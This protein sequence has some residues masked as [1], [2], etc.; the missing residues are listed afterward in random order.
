MEVTHTVCV[1]SSRTYIINTNDK[2][3]CKMSYKTHSTYVGWLRARV[4]GSL[5]H[6]LYIRRM[7][8][9]ASLGFTGTCTVHTSDGC[10]RESRVH[11]NMHSTCFAMFLLFDARLIV[12]R[13]DDCTRTP[14]IYT[15]LLNYEAVPL[16]LQDG[17]YHRWA[18]FYFI[19]HRGVDLRE[20]LYRESIKCLLQETIIYQSIADGVF[21]RALIIDRFP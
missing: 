16:S 18:A 10:V 13:S 12:F 19:V 5:E 9:C 1:S 6:V 11:C 8:A 17:V 20:E 21:V 3:Y 15:T 4:Q 7:S 14:I 2:H